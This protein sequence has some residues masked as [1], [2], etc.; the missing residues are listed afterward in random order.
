[1]ILMIFFPFWKAVEDG[2]EKVLF[3]LHYTIRI[4]GEPNTVYFPYAFSAILAV[5]AAT[6]AI[7]EIGKFEDRM[8]QIKLG[9]LNSLLMMGSL[10]CMVF[11]AT[12]LIKEN[13]LE[14]QYGLALW[15]PFI[16]MVSNLIANRFIR[17]DEKLVRDSDRIR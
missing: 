7:I 3:P 11:F 9:A 17:R 16:A 14:G 5:A 10:G 12:G 8:L 1:M 2:V 6:L 13:Q 4:Q 15:L